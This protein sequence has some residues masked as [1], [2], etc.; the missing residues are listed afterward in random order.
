MIPLNLESSVFINEPILT[1]FVFDLILL[2]F[3]IPVALSKTHT[4]RFPFVLIPSSLSALIWVFVNYIIYTSAVG[5]FTPMH[6]VPKI[7]RALIKLNWANNVRDIDIHLKIIYNDST[8][9]HIFYS[10]K[11][12]EHVKLN[13]DIQTGFGPE[14]IS[15]NKLKEAKYHIAVH[16]YSKEVPLKYS[17]A[18]IEVK[19]GSRVRRYECP[20]EGDGDWWYVLIL[21]GAS[22]RLSEINELVNHIWK[23][24]TY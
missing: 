21:D 3:Y 23:F 20:K 13:N 9:T 14:E 10:N 4:L 16:N 7:E 2:L 19:I 15:I 5:P 6:P 1:Y 17:N 12:N 24:Q 18:T 8:Y 22:G 11:G